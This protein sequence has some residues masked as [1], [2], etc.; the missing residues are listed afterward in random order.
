MPELPSVTGRQCI[1]AFEKIGFELD[2]V[3]GS[4]HILV[5]PGHPYVLTIPV[6]RKRAIAKGTLR[7]LIRAAGISVADF[8]ELL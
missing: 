8:I 7:E 1:R 6:H 5:K 2:R 3:R 4:H